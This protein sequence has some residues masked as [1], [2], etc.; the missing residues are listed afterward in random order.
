MKSPLTPAIEAQMKALEAKAA[1]TLWTGTPLLK[2]L[3][4]MVRHEIGNQD[5][6]TAQPVA[7]AHVTLED[8]GLFAELQVLDGSQ[9]QVEHSP[10]DLYLRPAP[11]PVAQSEQRE[12]GKQLVACLAR[13]MDLKAFTAKKIGKEQAERL[14]VRR[15]IAMTRAKACLRFFKKPENL[16]WLNDHV[17]NLEEGSQE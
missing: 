8:D 10:I 2:G 4:A 15:E 14:K 12:K 7:R 16:A 1:E 11:A 17:A 3:L 13:Y 6:G 9:M 5:Q